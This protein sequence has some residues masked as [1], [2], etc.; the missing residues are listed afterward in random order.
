MRNQ[1]WRLSWRADPRARPLADR[2]YNRQRVGA[3]QFVPPGRCLVLLTDAADAVW[4]TSWPI[5]DYVQH[6]WAGAM[7]NS[8]FRREGGPLASELITA[9]CAATRAHWPDLPSL[10]IVSF[11]DPA[12]TR[13]KRDPGRCYR[14]AGW[15]HVGHTAAGL[16]AFQLAPGDFPPAV[17]ARPRYDHGQGDLFELVGAVTRPYPMGGLDQ[18]STPGTVA[19]STQEGQP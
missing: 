8:L 2:H 4:V 19:E 11:V 14:R 17:P 10:G 6:A 13:R 15:T 9:A 3:A 7:V 18:P 16:L 1:P 5:A 12:K